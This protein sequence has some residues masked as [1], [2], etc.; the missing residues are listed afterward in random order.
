VAE[1]LAVLGGGEALGPGEV[2]LLASVQRGF[3]RVWRRPTVA[4][5]S[6][7]DELVEVGEPLEP[8]RIVNSNSYSLAAL[9]R[10]AGALPVVLPIARDTRDDIRRAFA[11]AA[12]DFVVSTGGVS[13]GDYDFVKPVLDELGA[14]IRFWRVNMKPG[15]PVVFALLRDRPLFGLPGN[16]VSSMVGFHLFVRPAIR[17]AMGIAADR[18]MRP[19]VEAALEN[20]L[21]PTGERR[22]YLRGHVR[23]SEGGLRVATKPAQGSGVLS[24]MVG[25]NGLVVMA[26]RSPAARAGDVVPVQLIGELG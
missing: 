4:I 17:K 23:W 3:V 1:G 26:E 12:A 14:T 16:P 13:V 8:G 10:E 24:S 6:T 18:L 15:K 19:V 20:D 21:R 5:V 9:V 7:G 25:A 22:T 2:G 11:E